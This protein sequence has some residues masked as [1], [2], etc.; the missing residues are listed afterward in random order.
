MT[1][2][3]I[4]QTK[5]QPVNTCIFLQMH[6]LSES[7]RGSIHG[8]MIEHVYLENTWTIYSKVDNVK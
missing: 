5:Y 3:Y 1:F 4:L 6:T 2:F 8:N 7:F